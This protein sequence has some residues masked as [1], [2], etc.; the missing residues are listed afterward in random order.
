MSYDIKTVSITPFNVMDVI[1]TLYGKQS[2][3][4]VEEETFRTANK[5]MSNKTATYV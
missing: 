3:N 4:Y 1:I 5:I 2:T